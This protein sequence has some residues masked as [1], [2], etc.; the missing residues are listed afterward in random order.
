MKALLVGGAGF[1]GTN[2]ARMLSA[3]GARVI[4]LD[5]LEPR[6]RSSSTNLLDVANVQFIQADMRDLEAM[7]ALVRE[8]SFDLI[9]NTA[10]Q[11]SHPISMTDPRFDAELNIIGHLAFLEAMK[12]EQIRVPIVYSSTSTAI[13]KAIS[14]PI[15][16]D[17][18]ETPLDIYSSNKLAAEKYYGIYHRVHGLNTVIIRFANL[19]GPFGKGFAEFGFVNYF[20]H[21]AASGSEIRIF[22]DGNQTRNLTYIDDACEAIVAAANTPSLYGKPVF[23]AHH[24]H[25]SVREIAARIVETFGGSVT[26]VAWPEDRKR[27]EVDDVMIS[28]TLLEQTTGWRARVT[29]REGLQRTKGKI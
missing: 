23:A 13:G 11:T 21:L 27:I 20:I 29:L 3:R 22:G 1:F 19:Y 28:S 4:A 2:L 26:H 5:S 17:H 12:L 6:L 25:V 7:R 16:E 18:P 15:T 24:E 8:G 14:V 10:G 9:V